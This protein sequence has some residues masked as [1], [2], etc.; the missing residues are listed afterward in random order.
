MLTHVDKSCLRRPSPTS[1]PTDTPPGGPIG[2]GRKFVIELKE[3]G[4]T[5]PGQTRKFV[6]YFSSDVTATS[7]ANGLQFTPT[8]GGTFSGIMQLGYVGAG[9]QADI[10]NINFLDQYAGV[11]S[12][13]PDTLYCAEGDKGYISFDWNKHDVNGPTS[14]GE[15]L[16]VM[17]P[18]QVFVES[19]Y[20]MNKKY[21]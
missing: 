10:S 7:G 21:T 3:P 15:L 4:D 18:H 12:Y 8:S 19:I 14:S 11:F 6:A 5:L 1:G 9:P 2:S 13:K 16:M 20:S 17:M